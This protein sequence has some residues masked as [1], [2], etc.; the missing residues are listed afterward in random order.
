MEYNT[1]SNTMLELVMDSSKQLADLRQKVRDRENLVVEMIREY[2]ETTDWAVGK[3]VNMRGSE[4]RICDYDIK[5]TNTFVTFYGNPRKKNGEFGNARRYLEIH[6]I[7]E[8][9]K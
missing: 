7:S 3:V 8:L 1:T 2:I 6:D 4:Y 5:P 9:V